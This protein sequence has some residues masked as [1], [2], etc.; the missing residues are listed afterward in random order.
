[1]QKARLSIAML[2]MFISFFVPKSLQPL[3]GA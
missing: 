1:M 2:N 3:A